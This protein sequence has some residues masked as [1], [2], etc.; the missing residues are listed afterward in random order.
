MFY[1]GHHN[2]QA[3]FIDILYAPHSLVIDAFTQRM[4][5]AT[6]LMA[7]KWEPSP[8]DGY[9]LM[10]LH[11]RRGAFVSRLYLDEGCLVLRVMWSVVFIGTG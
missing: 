2:K 5:S 7:G 4:R 10:A 8:F 1:A 3:I 11:S 6:V 9:Y